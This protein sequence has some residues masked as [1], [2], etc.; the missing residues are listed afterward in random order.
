MV[1]LIKSKRH[2]KAR[3]KGPYDTVECILDTSSY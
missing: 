1:K 2:N 3:E